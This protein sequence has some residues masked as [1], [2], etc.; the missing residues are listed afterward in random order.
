MYL[1]SLYSSDLFT[2]VE[3]SLDVFIE[4]AGIVQDVSHMVHENI[5]LEMATVPAQATRG[6]EETIDFEH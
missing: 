6:P 4:R 1:T 5:I 3:M 2:C